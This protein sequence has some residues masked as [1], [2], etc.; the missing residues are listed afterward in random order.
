MSLTTLC[1]NRWGFLTG[2]DGV[3]VLGNLRTC[4]GFFLRS[5]PH[6]TA[7]KFFREEMMHGAVKKQSTA[8]YCIFTSII[9]HVFSSSMFSSNF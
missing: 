8:I 7:K 2:D 4:S 6:A 5:I 9:P 1:I 3:L